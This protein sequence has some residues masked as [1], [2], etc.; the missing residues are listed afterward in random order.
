M[1]KL[2]AEGGTFGLILA[3]TAAVGYL[4]KKLFDYV[5][6]MLADK[7][8]QI[9]AWQGKTDRAL[10]IA[11]DSVEDHQKLTMAIEARNRIEEELLRRSGTK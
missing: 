3:L 5:D 1:E 11:Q 9:A 2:I 10:D 7:D 8:E 4:V 6:R